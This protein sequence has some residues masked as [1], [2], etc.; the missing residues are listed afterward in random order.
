MRK[1]VSLGVFW[2]VLI[3]SAAQATD[4]GWWLVNCGTNHCV[5]VKWGRSD[6]VTVSARQARATVANDPGTERG[7]AQLWSDRSGGRDTGKL[8]HREK[9]SGENPSLSS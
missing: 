8:S 9:K 7:N 5:S 2:T 1:L 6:R 3:S 4:S